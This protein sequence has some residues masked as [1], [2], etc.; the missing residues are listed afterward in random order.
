MGYTRMLANYAGISSEATYYVPDGCAY[1][2]WALAG[3]QRLGP[4]PRR[5]A[6]TGYAEFT[7]HSNYEQDQVNL[8]Y[9]LFIGRTVFAGNRLTQQI[10]GNL[11]ALAAGEKMW[12]TRQVTER[13][14][15]LAGAPVSSYCG[16][17]TAFLGA[18]HGYGNP[19]GVA[20]GDLGNLESY[21][22]NTCGAPVLCG[23][24]GSPA[25][26]A[27]WC[28]QLGM[29]PSAEAA[30]DPGSLPRPRTAR[31]PPGG[32]SAAS[33]MWY[34]P[35]RPPAG[36]HALIRPLTRW[37]TPGTPTTASSPL[38]GRGRPR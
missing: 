9:S 11:D 4:T 1:E 31:V 7:N 26:A 21:N 22:E 23:D 5:L 20:A 28:L 10:H 30:A 27:P 12:T 18:Y 24:A 35:V 2:V 33:Q 32:G 34:S 14:F 16:D 13:F 29:R 19:Q 25:R 6:L 17:K 8:Q 37:S 36:P 3:D 38:C 15:G